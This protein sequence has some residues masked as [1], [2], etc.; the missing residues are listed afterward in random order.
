MVDRGKF[1]IKPYTYVVQ[2]GLGLIPELQ[3]T[4]F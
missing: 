4:Y 3:M 2:A 1:D